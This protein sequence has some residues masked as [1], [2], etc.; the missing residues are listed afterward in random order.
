MSSTRIRQALCGT[1]SLTH[2]AIAELP[3]ERITS[4][5]VNPLA[6]DIFKVSLKADEVEQS[7]RPME[8]DKDI[9]IT[10][11]ARLVAGN[12]AEQ[13]QRFYAIP[14]QL[15]AMVRKQT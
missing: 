1:D 4:N 5:E 13:S 3:L 12:G 7:G 14:R 2:D 15:V 11:R 6:E 8:L 10:I 9:D